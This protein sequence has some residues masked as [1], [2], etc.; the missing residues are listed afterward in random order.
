MLCMN[1]GIGVIAVI[2][3]NRQGT[4]RGS[5]GPEQIANTVMRLIREKTDLDPWRRN[6]T[7]VVVEKNRLCGRTGPAC[8][9]FYNEETGRLEELSPEAAAVYEQGVSLAGDEFAAYS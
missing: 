9:L 4:I 3:V 6:V 7:K 2:H 8:Y 1:L 5:A